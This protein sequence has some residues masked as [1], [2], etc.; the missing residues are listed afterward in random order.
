MATAK[1]VTD[2]QGCVSLW[3][4]GLLVYWS[5]WDKKYSVVPDYNQACIE[6]GY[7]ADEWAKQ[8]SDVLRQ[9]PRAPYYVLVEDDNEE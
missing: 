5:V 7:T 6:Y 8:F 3:Q 1:P 4:A 9:L 2:G